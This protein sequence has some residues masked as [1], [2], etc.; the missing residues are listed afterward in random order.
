M[1]IE[2]MCKGTTVKRKIYSRTPAI[3]AAGGDATTGT[4]DAR[5]RECG[6]QDDSG[7]S[8]DTRSDAEANR[9]SWK[10]F[11]S[12]D[13]GLGVQDE[14]IVSRHRGVTFETARNFRVNGV[15]FQGNPAGT[16]KLWTVNAEEF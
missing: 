4:T 15:G 12:S 10:F 6:A 11:F 1:S 9:S 5:T 16:L 14:L 3:G 8:L 13:P 7:G 2:S